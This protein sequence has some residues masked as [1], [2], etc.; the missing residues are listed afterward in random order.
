MNMKRNDSKAL[1]TKSLDELNKQ[2]MSL[3]AELA[4]ARLEKKAG[5][6]SNPRQV[7]VLSD[8]I[9]RIKTVIREQELA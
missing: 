1:A 8:D 9:A 3:V 6:L 2:L 7:S 5:R 4:K